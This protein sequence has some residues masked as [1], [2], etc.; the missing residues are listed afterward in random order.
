MSLLPEDKRAAFMGLVIGAIT[1][2][3]ILSTMVFL[4]NRKY[5]SEQPAAAQS[6]H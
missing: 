4:T 5:A 2:L 3:V 6:A 1:L